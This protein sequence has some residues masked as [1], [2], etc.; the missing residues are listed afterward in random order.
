MKNLLPPKAKKIPFEIVMHGDKRIDNY[1]WMQ[2]KNNPGVIEYLEAENA[3]AESY[4]EDTK[5]LQKKIYNEIVGR[6]KL[7]DITVPYLRGDYLYYEKKQEGKNYSVYFRKKNGCDDEKMILDVN[8]IAEGLPFCYVEIYPSD[9]NKILA[10]LVDSKGNHSCDCYFLNMQTG[11]L[12]KDSLNSAGNIVWTNDN[13]S[14]FY[15]KYEAGNMGKQLWLHKLGTAKDELIFNLEGNKYWLDIKKSRSKEFIFLD[16]FSFLDNDIYINDAGSN[17]KEFRLLIP[18]IPGKRV[19]IE[20][21]SDKFYIYTNYKAPNY[22]V[23]ITDVNKPSVDYWKDFI[24]ENKNVKIEEINL[25]KEYL[26]V[27]ERDNGI[28]KFRVINLKN[29]KSH[30]VKFPEEVYTPYIQDNYEFDTKYLRFNYTSLSTPVSYYDHDMETGENILLKETEVKGGYDKKNYETERIFAPS[31]DGKQIPISIIYKKGIKKDGKAPLFLNSYG[32]YGISTE[33]FFNSFR[34][35]LLD[36]GFVYALAHIRGGGE[37][38]EQW[39]EEGKLLNKKN[40]FLDF[41]SCSEYLIEMGYTYKGGITAAGMSAGGLLMGAIANM[42]PELFKCILMKVGAVDVLNSLLDPNVPNAVLHFDELGNPDIKE[43][44]DYM[45]SYSPYENIAEKEYPDMI[46]T[47]GV[48]DISVPVWEPAKF[49]ARLREFNIGGNGI[50]LKTNFNSGHSG[51]SGRYSLYSDFAYEYA[52]ILK[53]YGI[54][55]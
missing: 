44:Y 14:V 27:T 16:S 25:F 53:S 23:M 13:S 21:A 6:I 35:S 48:N 33:V 29:N 51:A 31:H 50:I 40:T 38:G 45:K 32:S 4:M 2:D 49:T 39:Y 47:T 3:Y 8:K 10:Y 7:D 18:R 11:D 43:H 15:I 55:E 1:H 24:P 22:R 19:N 34:I 9:D 12:L 41:I 42:K 17:S 28:I 5:S 20:N 52:F 46:I 30:Y 54:K 26:A 36:R 37:L